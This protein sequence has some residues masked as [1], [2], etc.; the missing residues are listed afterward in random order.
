MLN[1]VFFCS[2]AAAAAAAFAPVATAVAVAGDDVPKMGK[3]CLSPI[4]V[5]RAKHETVTLAR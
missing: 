5:A 2:S 3:G 4:W 1:F